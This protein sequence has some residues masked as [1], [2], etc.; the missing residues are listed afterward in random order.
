MTRSTKLAAGQT[1]FPRSARRHSADSIEDPRLRWRLAL[2][3]AWQRKID[4]AITLSM[5]S[6]GLTDDDG[7]PAQ[8]STP[9]PGRLLARTEHAYDELAGIE[10]AMARIDDGTYGVCAGCGHAMS[11][12]WLADKPEERYCADC[13]LVL[14]RGQ[15]S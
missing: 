6:A 7:G 12:E 15:A 8:R 5:A 13:S 10:D 14:V 4:E 1:P 9:T 3:S 11:D 2:D